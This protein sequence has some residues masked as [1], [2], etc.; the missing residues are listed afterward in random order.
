M[1]SFTLIP[2]TGVGFTFF[3]KK[4]FLSFLVVTFVSLKKIVMLSPRSTYKDE[5][6]NTKEEKFAYQTVSSQF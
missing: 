6:K 2:K 5:K 4:C 3:K 1:K